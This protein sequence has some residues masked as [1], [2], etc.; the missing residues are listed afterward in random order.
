V[1]FSGL[2]KIR[3]ERTRDAA[4]GLELSPEARRLM[5]RH[6]DTVAFLSG[7]VEA[8]LWVDAVRIM[9]MALPRREAA[10]WACLNARDARTAESPQET[11]ATLV[12][13]EAWVFKPSDDLG[14]EAFTQAQLAGFDSAE[15][16]AA[17]AVHW[18]GGNMAPA[19]AGVMVPPGDGLTATAAAAAV[20]LAAAAGEPSQAEA[21]YERALLQA[22]D[23]ARG[24]SGR[25]QAGKKE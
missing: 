21:W 20:F 15:A 6:P 18:A 2:K 14:H 11:L 22:L 4:A 10:W 24:G 16:Y 17:L 1:D 19:D 5:A 25:L 7:C 12:A 23:I 9:A 13:A 8:G 3:F